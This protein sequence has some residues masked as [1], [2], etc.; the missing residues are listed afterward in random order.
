MFEPWMRHARFNRLFVVFD[1]D[2]GKLPAGT[3]R[4]FLIAD[5]SN[6]TV[7]LR[8]RGLDGRNDIAATDRPPAE[9]K[10]L[11]HWGVPFPGGNLYVVGDYT[12]LESTSGFSY[13]SAWVFGDPHAVSTVGG[14]WHEEGGVMLP[15]Q[16]AFAPGC[17]FG[18]SNRVDRFHP[19]NGSPTGLGVTG[20]YPYSRGIGAYIVSVSKVTDRGAVGLWIGY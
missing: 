2:D 12:Q 5:D 1:A 17:P 8:I 14:C 16:L 6:V 3:Y 19:S 15:P 11:S 13:L 20:S 7:R 4:L 9:I 18:Y 10:T